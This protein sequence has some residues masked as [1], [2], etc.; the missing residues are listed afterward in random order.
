MPI[1]RC[2]SPK[3]EYTN[4][5]EVIQKVLQMAADHPA[6]PFA[7]FRDHV[8]RTF[9]CSL[10]TAYS[11][12]REAKKQLQQREAQNPPGH[13]STKNR[14]GH[15][16]P[17]STP[18]DKKIQTLPGHEGAKVEDDTKSTGDAGPVHNVR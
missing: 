16:E 1:P 14:P 8:H 10:S 17:Q 6:M 7:E 12:I 9:N 11:Y 5:V 4:R 3:G 2:L 15:E 18:R 13:E